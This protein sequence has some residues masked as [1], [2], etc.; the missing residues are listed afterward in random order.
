MA[1]PRQRDWGR[2]TRCCG[3][4]LSEEEAAIRTCRSL[5]VRRR[6]RCDVPGTEVVRCEHRGSSGKEA[7]G[8]TAVHREGS[9]REPILFPQFKLGHDPGFRVRAAVVPCTKGL[10]FLVS[11]ALSRW[12]GIRFISHSRSARQP[13][14]LLA[15]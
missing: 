11:R 14:F 15:R 5:G 7:L 10:G 12:N 2:V 13:L 9:G 1:L 6:Y 3:D 8:I 4:I